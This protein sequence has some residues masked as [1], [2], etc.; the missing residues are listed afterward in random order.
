MDVQCLSLSK[1][2]GFLSGF[3]RACQEAFHCCRGGSHQ[4]IPHEKFPFEFE[5][6]LAR[7][8]QLREE[9]ASREREVPARGVAADP[10]ATINL[11]F[12]TV[13]E[14]RREQVSLMAQLAQQTQRQLEQSRGGI[15]PITTILRW[16]TV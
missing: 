4:G 3:R 5:Q 14:L 6:G 8:A 16:D 13:A 2:K 10:P 15:V 12:A 1:K 7:L 11:L 9:A